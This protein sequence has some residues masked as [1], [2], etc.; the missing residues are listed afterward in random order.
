MEPDSNNLQSY[1]IYIDHGTS[2]GRRL[3]GR[4][5]YKFCDYEDYLYTIIIHDKLYNVRSTDLKHRRLAIVD[6][7]YAQDPSTSDQHPRLVRPKTLLQVTEPISKATEAYHVT[8]LETDEPFG[9][10]A[11]VL[12]LDLHER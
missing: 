8:M 7:F 10:L 1:Q 6:T 11:I 12:L 4:F 5:S 9:Y 3:F 2:D